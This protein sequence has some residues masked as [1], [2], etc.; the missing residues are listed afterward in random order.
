MCQSVQNFSLIREFRHSWL[1][2]RSVILWLKIDSRKSAELGL[3]S[4][5][6]GT[7]QPNSRLSVVDKTELSLF[8]L[9]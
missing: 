4:T 2:S 8:Q 6:C 3:V 5:E 9:S 7:I 1:L